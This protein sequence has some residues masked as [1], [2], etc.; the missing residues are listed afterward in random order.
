MSRAIAVL[1]RVAAC[2]SVLHCVA[3]CCSVLLCVAV[4]CSVSCAWHSVA[5][6]WIMSHANCIHIQ[7]IP[8]WIVYSP[9]PCESY[10]YTAHSHVSISNYTHIQPI[11]MWIAYSPFS[12]E[13]VNHIDI[14]PIP[15]WTFQTIHIYSPFPCESYT[16]HIYANMWII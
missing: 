1:Q 15:I 11:P 3:V 9:F 8:M 4:C 12:C 14:Q 2:C 16:A 6:V 5:Y 7:P 13:Y 10:R